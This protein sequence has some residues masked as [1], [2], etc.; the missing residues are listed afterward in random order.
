MPKMYFVVFIVIVLTVYA[1]MHGFVYWRLASGLS[2]TAGQRTLS[3]CCCWP[4]P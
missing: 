2:L 3:S 1:G 4:E